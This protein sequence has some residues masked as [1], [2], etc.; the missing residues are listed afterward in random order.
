MKWFTDILTDDVG[1]FTPDKV[2]WAFGVV[3]F[4]GYAGWDLIV[5]KNPFHPAEYGTG[6]GLVLA[7]GGGAMW[8]ASRQKPSGPAQ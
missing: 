1:N 3:A 8:L 4:I 2:L 7:A 5:F 6:L